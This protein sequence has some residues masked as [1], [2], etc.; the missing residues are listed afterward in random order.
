MQADSSEEISTIAFLSNLINR[1]LRYIC[2]LYCLCAVKGRR[3]AL[4]HCRFYYPVPIITTKR[5]LGGR[6]R[7]RGRLPGEC[8]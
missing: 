2:S 1:V 3:N 7:P 5:Q 4:K 8:V 6:D